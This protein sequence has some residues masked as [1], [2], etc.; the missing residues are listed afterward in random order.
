MNSVKLFLYLHRT[1]R[2][3]TR[4]SF[5]LSPPSAANYTGKANALYT[6][7]YQKQNPDMAKINMLIDAGVNIRY[8]VRGVV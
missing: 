7:C 3:T 5:V 8:Q 1:A 2:T 4:P 6:A